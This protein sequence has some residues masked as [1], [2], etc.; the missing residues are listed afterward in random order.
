M[1][2]SFFYGLFSSYFLRPSLSSCLEYLLFALCQQS[3]STTSSD[4]LHPQPTLS[5]TFSGIFWVMG[6]AMNPGRTE[7]HRIPCLWEERMDADPGKDTDPLP[8]QGAHGLTHR[9]SS[10]AAVWVSP[11]TPA[12]EEA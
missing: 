1:A 4:G 9:P 5:F 6:V 10:R 11:I 12:L 7:L 3:P 8:Q 2:E